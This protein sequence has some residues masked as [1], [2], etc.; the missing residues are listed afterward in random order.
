MKCLIADD[1]PHSLKSIEI[2]LEN[3]SE[4]TIVAR[5]HDGQEAL[6]Q[7]ILHKPDLIL[8][9][10]QM[11][12]MNGFE[13]AQQVIGHYH[14]QIIFVTAYDEYA[15]QAFDINA[16]DYIVKP[17]DDARFYK[18]LNR[19]TERH[20]NK[21]IPDVDYQAAASKY[22]SLKSSYIRHVSV[23][24]G[25][26]IKFVEVQT[27]IWIE[28]ADQYCNIHTS[29]ENYLMRESMR[30]FEEHLE[31]SLFFRANRSAIVNIS[32]I[33]ELQLYKKNRY[34]IILT[35]GQEVELGA[36]KLASLKQLKAFG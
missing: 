36:G 23:K 5:C 10:I 19:A 16:V 12:G 24:K 27:I 31:P 14:P 21:Q 13:V 15:I 4:L 1:E 18:A 11:P 9:D 28:A 25:N 32:C 30:F 34:L 7:I 26:S 35:N 8:L 22:Q 2:L 33:R 17:Y 20:K 29:T 6:S 3:I